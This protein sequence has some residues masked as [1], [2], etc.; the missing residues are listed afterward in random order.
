M[1]IL[2][3]YHVHSAF[4]ADSSE[5]MERMVEQ[6]MQLGLQHICFT[7]HMDYD[8]PAQYLE[9]EKKFEF[10]VDVYFDQIKKLCETSDV[11]FL[12]KIRSVYSV[13]ADSNSS[14][15][16]IDHNEMKTIFSFM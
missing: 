4:S 9:T 6:G 13:V 1:K 8:F 7:D 3:D 14:I 16:T 10:D 11:E 12:N 5:A 2:G 15:G